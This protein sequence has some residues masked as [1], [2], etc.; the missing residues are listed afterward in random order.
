MDAEL[1]TKLAK[2]QAL[3]DE[4]ALDALLIQNVTNFAWM[5]AGAS[6]YI[7][8][9]NHLGEARLLVTPANRYLITNNI[10]APR[11]RKEEVLE[12]QGWEFVISPWYEPV[13]SIGR[14]TQGLRLGADGPYPGAQDLS[15][16]LIPMRTD[17]LPEEQKRFRILGQGCAQ[18][19][20]AAVA[21]LKPGMTE[22]EIAALL[23]EQ[24]QARE[25]LPIVNLIATDERVYAYRHPLPTGKV[26]ERYAMLVLCG[27]KHG[28]VAS[29]TR[30]VHFGALPDDLRRKAEAVADID[31]A[32]IAA[33]SP[34]RTLG[35]IFHIA[36]KK[37]AEHGFPGEWQLHHQGGPAGYLPREAI[38]I[39]GSELVVK[40][41][42]V[43]AWNPSITGTK[44]EDSI[45][46]KEDGVDILTQI[47][48]WPTLPI[49]VQGRWISRPAIL[50]I[51]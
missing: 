22:F 18:A 43:Y 9:T 44:S 25:I 28:M 24:T 12:S 46:V 29:I 26:L 4:R 50:E 23:G 8:T 14:L 20:E 34:E 13:D 11:L 37:Y 45:L 1:K 7:N 49:D 32:L 36:Q 40:V 48:G 38:A 30:L 19:M 10:E 42:Q 47:P 15:A 16:D 31:A 5:T 39:P 17:L 27:R 3:L 51:V 21:G 35:E 33:T 2:L 41:G 6:S